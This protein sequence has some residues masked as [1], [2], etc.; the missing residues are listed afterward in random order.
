M[1]AMAA[2][3]LNKAATEQKGGS[4]GGGWPAGC[5]LVWSDLLVYIYDVNIK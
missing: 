4:I 2:M 3:E 5:V 1:A